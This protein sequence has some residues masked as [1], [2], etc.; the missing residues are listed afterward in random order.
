MHPSTALPPITRQTLE[1]AIEAAIEALD[2]FDGDPD[3]EDDEREEI[4]DAE[5]DHADNEPSLGWSEAYSE[6]NAI[7]LQ[8]HPLALVDG[9]IDADS[10]GG[11]AR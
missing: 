7:S 11:G 6:R 1:A 9:E 4:H 10:V 5:D 2:A 8:G 3:L